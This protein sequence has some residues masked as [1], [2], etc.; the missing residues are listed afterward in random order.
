MAAMAA[1]VVPAC[2]SGEAQKMTS[3]IRIAVVSEAGI[4]ANVIKA[5]YDFSLPGTVLVPSESAK[6]GD[7]YDAESGQF[8]TPPPPALT[9]AEATAIAQGKLDAKARE[10]GYDNI[11]SLC[12]YAASS[13]P[14]F[15]SEASA[16]NSWRD[17]MW[18][19]CYAQLAFIEAGTRGAPTAT[20]WSSEL[21]A[22]VE[23]NW[24]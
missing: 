21:N 11:V 2:M 16:G 22:N 5:P 19:Y 12:S 7:R 24:P 10:R 17:S 14:T 1:M 13:N 6:I 3:T 23:M 4:V 20:E 9:Q 8:S 18:D 15:S